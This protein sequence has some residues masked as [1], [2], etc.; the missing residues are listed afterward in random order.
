MDYFIEVS[1][2][3]WL[4]TICFRSFWPNLVNHGLFSC[5]RAQIG[6]SWF[7]FLVSGPNWSNT[8]DRPN[9]GSQ[10]VDYDPFFL[11]WLRFNIQFLISRLKISQVALKQKYINEFVIHLYINFEKIKLYFSFNYYVLYL[12]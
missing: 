12:D 5:F 10:L 2:I 4:I 8:A 11:F 7:V 1:G 9:F 6:E 3:D